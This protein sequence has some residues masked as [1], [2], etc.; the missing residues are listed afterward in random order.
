MLRF[1]DSFEHY[2]DSQLQ[3]KYDGGRSGGDGNNITT[4]RFGN[5]FRIVFDGRNIYNPDQI[6]AQGFTC[7][8]MGRP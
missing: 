7:Y 6:R 1:L 2:S 3:D 5:G 8:S 4:G